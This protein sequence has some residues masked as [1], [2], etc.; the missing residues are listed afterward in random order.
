MEQRL[1]EWPTKGWPNLRPIPWARTN[2]CHYQWLCYAC[3]QEPNVTVFWEAPRMHSLISPLG[4]QQDALRCS[5]LLQ[6]TPAGPSLPSLLISSRAPS[7]YRI[8]T[9]PPVPFPMASSLYYDFKVSILCTLWLV[10]S[11]YPS[12]PPCVPCTTPVVPCTHT[13]VAPSSGLHTTVPSL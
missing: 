8:T 5:L 12:M 9:T 6:G 2:P 11:S 13:A 1:R 7:P 10:P 4:R 3:R